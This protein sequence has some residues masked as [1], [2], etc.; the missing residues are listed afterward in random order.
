MIPAHSILNYTIKIIYM[1]KNHFVIFILLI[2][3][4]FINSNCTK[5]IITPALLSTPTHLKMADANAN[6]T[7]ELPASSIMLNG[8]AKPA[9]FNTHIILT[10]WKKIIGPSACVIENANS[11]QTKVSNLEKGIYKFELSV[12]D[13]AGHFDIDTMTLNVVDPSGTDKHIL[14]EGIEMTDDSGPLGGYICLEI[15]NFNEFIPVNTLFSVYMKL[16]SFSSWELVNSYP[17]NNSAFAGYAYFIQGNATSSLIITE[18]P[19]GF[20]SV[21]QRDV[22]IAY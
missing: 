8:R 17:Q 14:F 4:L 15:E 10:A 3:F 16:S 18:V 5:P 13:N 2:A 22:K 12:W 9:S 7:I 6:I 19:Y 1:N 21:D 11:I 20:N